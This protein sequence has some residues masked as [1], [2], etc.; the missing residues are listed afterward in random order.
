MTSTSYLLNYWYYNVMECHHT[1]PKTYKETFRN[2][3]S[4]DSTS[5]QAASTV[6]VT[7]GRHLINNEGINRLTT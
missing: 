1:V 3:K 5:G 6:L 7:L 4:K 2:Q